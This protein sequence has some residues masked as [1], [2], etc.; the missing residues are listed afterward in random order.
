MLSI[1]VDLVPLL[2]LIILVSV[3]LSFLL[4]L[5][6]VFLLVVERIK[7]MLDELHNIAD[8]L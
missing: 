7:P 6:I 3:L 4:E 2:L 1:S 8:E 5:L